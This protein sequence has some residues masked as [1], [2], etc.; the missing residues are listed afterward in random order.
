MIYQAG[1]EAANDSKKASASGS[2]TDGSEF[3]AAENQEQQE[4]WVK[5]LKYYATLPPSKQLQLQECPGNVCGGGAGL[6][7]HALAADPET[8]VPPR[9]S[10]F[11]VAGT[12]DLL[13]K[14]PGSREPI[15][16]WDGPGPPTPLR[17]N[18]DAAWPS[19]SDLNRS[20]SSRN[21]RGPTVTGTY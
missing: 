15:A 7:Q 3:F 1:I 6:R 2:A 13:N 19:V 4:E 20:T 17:H 8:A 21:L 14:K 5:K 11:G 12:R 9:Q 18:V 16:E 10:D